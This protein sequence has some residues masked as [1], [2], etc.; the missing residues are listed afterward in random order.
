MWNLDVEPSSG[1]DDA[2]DA[3]MLD[4]FTVAV[5]VSKHAPVGEKCIAFLLADE[6]SIFAKGKE[7]SRT[8]HTT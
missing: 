4:D 2:E 8:L 5:T 1:Y 3:E 6:V 7:S